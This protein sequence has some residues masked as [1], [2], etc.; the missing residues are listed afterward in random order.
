MERYRNPCARVLMD[1]KGKNVALYHTN[2]SSS[3]TYIGE[4]NGASGNII[5]LDKAIVL[6]PKDPDY[7]DT[8]AQVL[9]DTEIVRSLYPGP[10]V[11]IEVKERLMPSA[12]LERM[13]SQ[14][15]SGYSQ[16]SSGLP[17]RHQ[18]QQ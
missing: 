12:Q 13:L 1:L 5:H 14:E 8:L 10:N 2:N 3:T 18:L 6:D 17:A 15:S 11:K 4:Y 9:E 7:N 16:K